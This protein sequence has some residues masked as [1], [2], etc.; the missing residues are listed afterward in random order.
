VH[1]LPRFQKLSGVEHGVAGS[2]E[3]DIR[4]YELAEMDL[5]HANR[6]TIAISNLVQGE[7]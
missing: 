1:L 4:R 6:E 3:T 5:V 7:M 2:E